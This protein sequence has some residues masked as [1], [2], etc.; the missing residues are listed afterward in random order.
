MADTEATKKKQA[1]RWI[2][3]NLNRVYPTP[4]QVKTL[5]RVMVS[6]C[7]SYELDLLEKDLTYLW[8]KEY[9]FYPDD[10]IGGVRFIDKCIMLTADGKEIADA[11]QTDPALEI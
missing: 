8:Q 1:R 2:L 3:E 4:L 10:V 11:T 6:F 7:A 5:L 9:I